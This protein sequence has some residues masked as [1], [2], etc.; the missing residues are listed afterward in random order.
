MSDQ[1]QSLKIEI[2][3]RAGLQPYERIAYHKILGIS[4]TENGMHILIRDLIR[5]PLVRESAIIT[6]MDFNYIQVLNAFTDLLGQDIESQEKIHILEYMEKYGTT[7]QIREVINCIN[8]NS[9]NP[10]TLHIALKAFSTL[11]VIG[12]ESKEVEEHLIKTALNININE[13]IRAAA[14]IALS[15]FKGIVSVSDSRE[16]AFIEEMLKDNSEEILNASYKALAILNDNIIEKVEKNKTDDDQLYT[17]SPELEDRA[18]LDI[19]VILGKHTSFFD[20]YS[21]RIKIAFI[22]AMISSNHREFIIY[23]MKALTSDD[24][25]LVDLTLE[26]ILANIHKLREPDKLLRNLIALSI[27]TPRGNNTIIDIFDNYFSNLRE[28]RRNMLLKDKLYNYIVVTLETYFE[29]FRTDFMI[30]EVIEKDY[31]GNIQSIRNFILERL[32]PVYKKKIT[33]FLRSTDT[34][35]INQILLEISE[36]IPYL[37]DDEKGRLRNL[38]EILHESDIKTRDISAARLED[39][40]FEKR[41]LKDRIIRLCRIIARLKID[42]AASPLVI[43]YNYLKKYTDQDILNTVISTLSILN[44][45]YM[46][47]ELEVMLTTGDTEEQSKAVQYLSLFSDQR[48]LNILLDFLKHN[49]NQ[50]PEITKKI[51]NRLLQVDISG[52]ITANQILKT[53]IESAADQDIKK[54]AILCIGRCGREADITYLNELFKILKEAAP[55]ESIAQSIERIVSSSKDINKRI[56]IKHLHEYLKDPGI[57]VRIYSCFVLIQLGDKEALK[58][59][60]DMMTIKNKSIQREILSILGNLKSLE[61]AYFLISLLK[62]EYAIASD[63]IPVL[64]ILPIEDLKEIDHFIVNIF[65][66]IEPIDLEDGSKLLISDHKSVKGL[67]KIRKSI[68]NIEIP[69]LQHPPELTIIELTRMYQDISNLITSEITK[70]NG[71]ITRTTRGLISSYFQ[72]VAAASSTALIINRNIDLYNSTRL[73]GERI[74]VSIQIISEEVGLINEEI[75]CYPDIKLRLMNSIP[76]S[77]R[78][79]IDDTS[80]LQIENNYYSTPMPEF[81]FEQH[82][83]YYSFYELLSPLNFI[84]LSQLILQEIIAENELRT[85]KE[86]ELE[87]EVREQ[88]QRRQSGT[89]L[90]YAQ[91]LDDIG[92]ILKNDLDQI[93]KYIQKRSTDRELINNVD[94]LLS[95]TYKR[96]F[97][98]KSKIF[99]DIK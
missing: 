12:R 67:E 29:K 36:K 76:F 75:I 71:L 39:I 61:F 3:K 83:F 35:A 73:P 19:R 50:K 81:N 40:N 87:K 54:I 4:K 38:L 52:N 37:L 42:N 77:N 26:L 15:S 2:S 46:L 9:G 72:D 86:Q 28:I 60:K 51:L 20:S 43:I 90:S 88:K 92:R 69:D 89:V 95:N 33:N 79:I 7:G 66:K 6:L 25:T 91:A 17:Y 48:S 23:T 58:S 16:K 31:P 34:S 78:I 97:V 41:H 45:S 1:I 96:Y 44:Y 11:R 24:E 80:K 70:N 98:E 93:N 30:T 22:N 55:K 57:R 21:N 85:K 47:G 84:A 8:K 56:V 63:I 74:R 5:E 82:G 65:K 62:E 27:D 13:K 64:R 94:K 53:I 49:M 68:L 32:N 59:I 10:K 18:V 14:V 99:S